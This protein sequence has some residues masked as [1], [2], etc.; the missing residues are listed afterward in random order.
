MKK[1]T[2]KQTVLVAED[3]LTLLKVLC[4]ALE[5]EGFNVIKTEDGQKALAKALKHHPDIILLDIVMPVM[6]GM[7]MLKLLRK[8][9]WGANVYVMMLTNLEPPPDL[10]AEASRFPYVSSYYMKSQYGVREIISIMKEKL[11]KHSIQKQIKK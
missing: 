7:T 10:I 4:N 5:D 2:N 1:K 8:D 6:D 3:D 11:G 9:E